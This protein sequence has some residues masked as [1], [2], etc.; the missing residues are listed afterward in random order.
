MV[1]SEL[2]AVTEAGVSLV[3]HPTVLELLRAMTFNPDSDP[4]GPVGHVDLDR[5]L[6]WR[7]ASTSGSAIEAALEAARRAPRQIIETL[8]AADQ[9]L[10]TG[11]G[12]SYYLARAVA[13]AARETTGRKW[14]AAPLSEVILRP[15]GVLAAGKATRQPIVVISRSGRTS[16]AVTV[17]E[18]MR[19]AG[20]KTIAVTCR[21]GSPL[22]GVAATTLVS[23]A[24]DEEAVVM[25]R[26]FASMLALLLR[27]V[28]E[29]AAD[30]PLAADLDR[31]PGSWQDSVAAA[32]VGRQ[33]GSTDRRR[34]VILGGGP[35]L[36]IA[37]EWGLKLTE[38]S[39]IA[40]NAYEPL[41][42]RHGPISVCEPGV[43][44][45]GLLGGESA[46]EEGRVIA[47]A[48]ALGADT[49]TIAGGA[50]EAAG[51]T[52]HVSLVGGGLRPIAR[53]PLLLYPGQALALG[54]ALT[55]GRNPDEPRHLG[56]VV[57]LDP[58]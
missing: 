6:T 17:A 12:S 10:L 11:A 47:E 30:R 50:S 9:V 54:L 45:V 20:H 53:L 3:G 1:M 44:V 33:L 43:L 51:V 41:E 7:E 49:W 25:T 36:G 32:S 42:F 29:V 58:A 28:A 34:I 38:T 37:I 31:V 55:R 56:Q 22:A 35:A 48:A 52:G 8:R 18:R 13:A 2:V 26:S 4:I 15:S 23:P 46:A 57:T 5:L 39:Q 14:V 21:S 24:G 40:S 16:E 19:S 27:V